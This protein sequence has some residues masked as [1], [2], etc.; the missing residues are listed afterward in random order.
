[1]TSNRYQLQEDNMTVSKEKNPEN[2]DEII[3]RISEGFLRVHFES[4]F[5]TWPLSPWSPCPSKVILEK[6][7][8]ISKLCTSK[9][10][11]IKKN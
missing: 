11:K 3:I 7:V 1:M 9:T 6:V 8:L 10:F 4:D 2:P 5:F